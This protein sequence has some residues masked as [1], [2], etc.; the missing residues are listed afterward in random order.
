MN[1]DDELPRS[2]DALTGIARRRRQQRRILAGRLR[3][4]Q[5]FSAA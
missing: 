2:S 5:V 3:A 1:D 4:A